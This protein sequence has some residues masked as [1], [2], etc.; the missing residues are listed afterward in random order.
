MW[1]NRPS[2]LDLILIFPSSNSNSP[3]INRITSAKMNLRNF[4]YLSYSYTVSGGW[5]E[6]CRDSREASFLVVKMLILTTLLFGTVTLGRG[7][8]SHL[9][10]KL[11]L[12][13]FSSYI[14]SL[15]LVGLETS[16]LMSSWA[17]YYEEVRLG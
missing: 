5:G 14:H 16:P 15:D 9:A 10:D 2:P 13:V 1:V 6:E 3:K 11:Y 17:M 12:T 7:R 8:V 4:F